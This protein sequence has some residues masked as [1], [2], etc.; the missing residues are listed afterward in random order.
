MVLTEQPVGEVCP[1]ER[2]RMD[3]RTVLQWDKD[4]CAYMGLVKFDFL[5]L[6]ILA[7][8]QYTFDL[9]ADAIGE[10]WTLDTVPKEVYA[11]GG[12]G[13][14]NC[15]DASTGKVVW[16]RDAR[17][18][19]GAAVPMWGFASSP[20]VLQG[21]VTVFTGGPEDKSVSAY[22]AVNGG[23]PALAGGQREPQLLLAAARAARRRRA[24]PHRH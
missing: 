6:G 1:I 11:L 19:A 4:S 20:L 16:T 12:T 10:R 24:N 14:L 8:I 3:D 18:D 21:L 13:L 15:L 7:A 17:E 23:E 9:V 2:G 5:G 22:D